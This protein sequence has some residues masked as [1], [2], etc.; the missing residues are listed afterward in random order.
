MAR[1]VVY[2]L[3]S[4]GT[5]LATDR[6]QNQLSPQYSSLGV[7]N[8]QRLKS[9]T[10]TLKETLPVRKGEAWGFLAVRNSV[11]YIAALSGY[12]LD[13][14]P[15]TKTLDIGLNGDEVVE[16]RVFTTRNDVYVGLVTV[17]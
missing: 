6:S 14:R 3:P 11:D 5:S 7:F 13:E 4:P 10:L 17:E 12:I 1:T 8:G 9:L 16:F 2:I 15:L